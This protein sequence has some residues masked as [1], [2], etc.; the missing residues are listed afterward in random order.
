MTIEFDDKG[1]FYTDIISKV[2]VPAMIQTIKQRIHGMVYVNPH[3]RFRD[4]MDIGERFIAV[5]SAT[6][7]GDTG[8]IQYETDFMTI[9]RDQIIWVIPE[10]EKSE[11]TEEE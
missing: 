10:E 1:K 2:A 11:E 8:E 5:T 3:K 6:I 9:S 7:F 4:E